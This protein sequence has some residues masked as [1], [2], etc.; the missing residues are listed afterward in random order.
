MPWFIR[1]KTEGRAALCLS[2]SPPTG[3]QGGFSIGTGPILDYPSQ[4]FPLAE[5]SSLFVDVL[6]P[7]AHPKQFSLLVE[8]TNGEKFQATVNGQP[9][10][11]LPPADDFV[12]VGF[13]LTR[14]IEIGETTATTDAPCQI[15]RLQ[16]TVIDSQEG[17]IYLDN[18]SFGT[19][20]PEV[21]SM[22]TSIA[23]PYLSPAI[24]RGNLLRL[25][26]NGMPTRSNGLFFRDGKKWSAR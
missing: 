2:Y 9:V 24:G 26:P 6:N 13:D 8:N 19:S 20:T 12:T 21:V 17:S 11:T 7:D 22:P 5:F 16:F 1:E 18:V 23:Q 10:I 4:C 25:A 3:G 15:K 14:L